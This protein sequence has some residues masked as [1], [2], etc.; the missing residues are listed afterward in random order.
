MEF[1]GFP[2]L[3]SVFYA[4]FHP[5]KGPKVLYE[6][7]E[8]SVLPTPNITP[9]VDFDSISEYIVPKEELSDRLVTITTGHHKVIGYPVRL[10][11]IRYHKRRNLFQFNLCFVFDK[12]AET[13]SYDPVVRKC[14]RV[15]K[16]IE[17]EN[18]F[19][20][21]SSTGVAVQN[22]IEQ[23]LEDLN[24][25]CECQIPINPANTINLK[26][27]PTYP[28]PP[29]VYDYQ[30]PILTVNVEALMDVSW[31][32]TMQRIAKHIDGVK[33]VRKIAHLAEVEPSL[34]RKCME[35]LLYYMCI[36]MVDIFQFGNIY[37]TRPD[38]KKLTEDITLQN[39]CISYCTKPD[40]LPPPFSKILNIYCSLRHG[41]TLR[42]WIKQYDVSSYNI[43]IRRF[44]SFG[45]MKGFLYRVHKYPLLL[46]NV[47]PENTIEGDYPASYS[48]ISP[49]LR[50][51]LTGTHHY[52]E[53]CTALEVS[54][55]ELD[56]TL[57]SNPNVVFLYR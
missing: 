20:S 4:E 19:L 1:Q 5:D 35:H 3:L 27:F 13:S 25:Y 18:L 36:I 40:M 7:P 32:I 16:A 22:L 9:L 53:I 14:A 43:D 29:P 6:V 12:D 23:L 45:V 37:A 46:N 28:N 50:K 17:E 48:E 21:N 2:R 15:L 30:V 38:V 57:R 8:G 39:E 51:Y 44:I 24:S 42:D 52:D 56:D 41:L 33:H 11:G 26:L 54:A 34:A 49:R 10:E 31:D 47:Q 55:R